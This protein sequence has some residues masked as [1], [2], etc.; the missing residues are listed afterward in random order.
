MII[1]S[2]AYQGWQTI[3]WCHPQVVGCFILHT[4]PSLPPSLPPS[5]LSLLLTLFSLL[6]P[7]LPPSLPPYP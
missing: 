5:S 7:S 3:D 4:Y 6:P 1:L 2:A